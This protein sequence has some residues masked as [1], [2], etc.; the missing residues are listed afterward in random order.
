MRQTVLEEVMKESLN[1]MEFHA[2]STGQM[3]YAIIYQIEESS[4]LAKWNVR[5]PRTAKHRRGEDRWYKPSCRHRLTL[6][7]ASAF[8][9]GG[10]MQKE[11]SM[12]PSAVAPKDQGLGTS[13][14]EDGCDM[15][16]SQS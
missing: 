12:P 9:K 1:R 7:L 16:S 15:L 10:G 6:S 11:G 2:P 4:W 8:S 5:W 14:R 13:R 3:T